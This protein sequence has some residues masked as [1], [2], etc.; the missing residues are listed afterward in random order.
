MKF[1]NFLVLKVYFMPQAIELC[2]MKHKISVRNPTEVQ[3]EYYNEN[4]VHT[5]IANSFG[6]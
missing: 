4:C 5:T 1:G 3:N 2:V 6:K